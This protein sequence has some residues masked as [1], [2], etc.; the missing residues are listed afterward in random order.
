MTLPAEHEAAIKRSPQWTMTGHGRWEKNS[1]ASASPAETTHAAETSAPVVGAPAPVAAPAAS[2][3]RPQVAKPLARV[4]ASAHHPLMPGARLSANHDHPLMDRGPAPEVAESVHDTPAPVSAAKGPVAAAPPAENPK[5]APAEEKGFFGKM[6][7]SVKSFGAKAGEG[8]KS[9]GSWVGG[10][11]SSL[12]GAGR[13]ATKSTGEAI[14][15]GS[16]IIARHTT[17]K[18]IDST[19]GP[20]KFQPKVSSDALSWKSRHDNGTGKHEIH[21]AAEKKMAQAIDDGSTKNLLHD[22]GSGLSSEQREQLA[23]NHMLSYKLTQSGHGKLYAKDI[24]KA[25]SAEAVDTSAQVGQAVAETAEGVRRVAASGINNAIGTAGETATGVNVMNVATHGAMLAK[26]A[27]QSAL[28]NDSVRQETAATAKQANKDASA[29]LKGTVEDYRAAREEWKGKADSELTAEQKTARSGAVKKNFQSVF[30]KLKANKAALVANRAA[31]IGGALDEYKMNQT[32][33]VDGS[34]GEVRSKDD[35]LAHGADPEYSMP[36]GEST[37][38]GK[39]AQLFRPAAEGLTFAG[40]MATG[41]GAQEYLDKGEHAK[42]TA[43]AAG[44]LGS[45]VAAAA[46]NVAGLGVGVKALTQGAGYGALVLG[47][48]AKAGLDHAA[49]DQDQHD[50]YNDVMS[51][52]RRDAV[53]ENPIDFQGAQRS[54]SLGIKGSV[55]DVAATAAKGY[56]RTKLGSVEDPNT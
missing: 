3:V 44:G 52:A 17:D 23:K 8:L 21:D 13:S 12:F 11:L 31:G 20:E 47:S 15:K 49:S 40:K 43:I 41:I 50:R 46:G 2:A 16:D 1:G 22:S 9:F 53:S 55:Q 5:A 37:L 45:E 54:K 30:A 14:S 4:D 6:W 48:A 18:L 38:S 42:A 26:I 28:E 25:R 32:N 36:M 33:S 19:I 29:H 7:D 39:A 24:A 27:G 10:G 56:I 35:A 51:G 34:T